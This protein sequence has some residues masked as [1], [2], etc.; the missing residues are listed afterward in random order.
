MI[1]EEIVKRII[2]EKP[3]IKKYVKRDIKIINID[4]IKV[5]IGPRRAGKT[6]FLF[7]IMDQLKNEGILEEQ[8][9]YINFEDERLVDIEREDLQKIIDIFYSLYPE[10][11]K[12]KVIFMFD[13]IQ[14]VPYWS[15]FI[16]RLYDKESCDIYITGSS[17]KLLSK[18]IATE[19][20]GRSWVY[21]IFPF[22]F[23]EFIGIKDIKEKDIYKDIY[24]IK[25]EF[26]N[27]L[28]KGGFPEVIN[29]DSYIRC[30]VLQDYYETVIFKDIVERYKIKNID[31]VK[32]VFKILINNFSRSISINKIYNILKSTNRHISK[33]TLYSI[34]SYVEDT[35]Y[36]FFVPIFSNSTNVR[37]MNPKKCYIIDTGLI[38]CVSTKRVDTGWLYENLVA[39]NL[40][41][42]GYEL[43]YF[44]EKNECDFIAIN[45]IKKEKIAIQVTLDENK[46]RE[47]KGLIEAM[48]KLK[49]K[50][51]IIINKNT[52][53]K[54]KINNKEILL[55]P[56]WRWLFSF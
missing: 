30:V 53:K 42:K 40:I 3:I 14:N 50:R 13:E 29:Y 33:E 32:D 51:G 16:R 36:F 43:F 7:Q 1:D 23:K 26:K 4:K 38:N 20:R 9:L 6:Y 21:L 55:I 39:I 10:N 56:I 31:I 11:K 15:K 19:L 5:I 17:S 46:E 34:I 45:K 35:F 28:E 12:R 27:Y 25:K 22:S 8:I 47:I 18:E 52:Y 41:R 48:E 44:K 49:I 37:I 54:L 24:K 2:I